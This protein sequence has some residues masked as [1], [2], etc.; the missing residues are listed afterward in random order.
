MSRKYNPATVGAFVLGAVLLAILAVVFFGGGALFRSS[1]TH[2][3]YFPGSIKGLD[4][5]APVTF[6]GVRVG[7]VVD[8]Q[9]VYDIDKN[10]IYLPVIYEIDRGRLQAVGDEA[11]LSFDPDDSAAALK[12]LIGLGLRARLDL[13]SLVTGQLIVEL[14]M[15]P[16]SPAVLKAYPSN[17]L[18]I[19][20]LPTSIE[21]L[22]E[23][24]EGFFEKLEDLPISDMVK[25]LAD[26]IAG[27]DQLINSKR[28][29]SIAQGIDRFVNSP[30][31]K[32]SLSNLDRA[33]VSF[34][35]AMRSAQAF[36]GD[37]DGR[38]EP[39]FESFMSAS[40]A[41]ETALE[42]AGQLIESAKDSISE[43]SDLRARSSRAIVEL[44]AAAEAVR[45]LADYLARH[46]EALIKGKPSPGDE[47]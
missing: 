31:L 10:L 45:V 13:R 6:R 43:D 29:A 32:A 8:I 18:E 5:G 7:S 41:L 27:V 28:T 2:V 34:D 14:D 15:Y 11:K 9:A 40:A 24:I 42:D 19:P 38:L 12:H 46:P 47:R 17:Y 36:M 35:A 16:N 3:S 25:N 33:L 37:A 4:V 23:R 39:A 26:A 30:E 44:E 1:T 21:Q 20:A 22:K